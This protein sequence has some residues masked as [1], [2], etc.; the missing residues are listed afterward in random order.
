MM[1]RQTYSLDGISGT[2][3][4]KGGKAVFTEKDG[5]DYAAT[6]VQMPGGERVPFLFSVKNLI[7]TG[8]DSTIKPGFEMGGSFT[9]PS[10]RTGLF[11]DP[12]GRGTTTGYDFAGALP[13]LQ[14][15]YE[16]VGEEKLFEENNKKF[17]VLSGMQLAIL[18][19]VRTLRS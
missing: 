10:Y 11:L 8:S 4:V 17:D 9:V 7:A 19:L 2:I 16:G 3:E 18:I 13:G 14:N 5:I 12:K 6:T 15:G 1:T